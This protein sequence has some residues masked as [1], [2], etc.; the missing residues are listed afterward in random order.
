MQR[1]VGML[2][3]KTREVRSITNRNYLNG[4]WIVTTPIDALVPSLREMIP[5]L[6]GVIDSGK[7]KDLQY[8]LY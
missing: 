2:F 4:I 6:E 3:S 1:I 7:F 5:I 8:V